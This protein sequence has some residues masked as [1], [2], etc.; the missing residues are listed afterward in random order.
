[1]VSMDQLLALFTLTA[2]AWRAPVCQNGRHANVN[3]WDRCFPS[4]R[5]HTA[6]HGFASCFVVT[7]PPPRRL[8]TSSS[9]ASS[10]GSSSAASFSSFG[11][12]N[13]KCWRILLKNTWINL[14]G[15]RL[16]T[17]RR[18]YNNA[19]IYIERELDSR[20]WLQTVWRVHQT[21]TACHTIIPVLR[22]CSLNMCFKC[23]VLQ[24]L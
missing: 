23:Q 3:C 8:K 12:G 15:W 18:A 13:A 22:I 21:G 17:D 9:L 4:P 1:M 19:Y 6:S 10:L 7:P 2:P 20:H 11:F 16:K 24:S 5:P 14:L